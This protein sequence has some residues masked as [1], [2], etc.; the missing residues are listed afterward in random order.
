MFPTPSLPPQKRAAYDVTDEGND[1]SALVGA[2]APSLRSQV[3]NSYGHVRTRE[4]RL[5][6]SPVLLYRH[7]FTRPDTLGG[8]RIY[9][10][11]ESSWLER[12]LIS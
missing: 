11:G 6:K 10:D 5:D 12:S 3:T 8:S 2:I 7:G 1:Q 9:I 4:N